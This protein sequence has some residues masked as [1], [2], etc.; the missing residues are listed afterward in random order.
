MS[1][2]RTTFNFSILSVSSVNLLEL[3][4]KI[5]KFKHHFNQSEVVNYAFLFNTRTGKQKN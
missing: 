5:Q 2:L 4:N 1:T 3:V